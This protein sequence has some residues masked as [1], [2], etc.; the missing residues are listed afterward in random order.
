MPTPILTARQRAVL[1]AICATLVPGVP[2]DDDPAGFFAASYEGTGLLERVEALIGSLAD[3]RDRLRLRFLLEALGSRLANLA[4]GGR[5]QPFQ[6]D[7]GTVRNHHHAATADRERSAQDLLTALQRGHRRFQ[8]RLIGGC[9]QPQGQRNVV[10]RARSVGAFEEDHAG[11][12]F[13]GRHRQAVGLCA[14]RSLQD[15]CRSATVSF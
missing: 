1:E 13:T 3:P 15:S 12:G 10:D 11:L 4:T 7:G 8:R 5:L 9:A 2:A 14:P 6:G